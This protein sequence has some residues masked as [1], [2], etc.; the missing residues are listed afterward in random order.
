MTM[1][2]NI[3]PP[4]KPTPPIALKLKPPPSPVLLVEDYVR[5]N[6]FDKLKNLIGG[7]KT[8]NAQELVNLLQDIAKDQ[9]TTLDGL[10][11]RLYY[12]S[13]NYN[14]EGCDIEFYTNKKTPNPRYEKE[15]LKYE[16]YL[17]YRKFQEERLLKKEAEYKEKMGVY[18]KA[19]ADYSKFQKE[20]QKII[21]EANE[22][23]KKL[24]IK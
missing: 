9:E 13:D 4:K 6:N 16:K 17:I 3:I 2:N 23:I 12:Y 24:D 14:D 22:K 19:L 1:I 18:K 10:N 21:K 20:R 8:F 11:I 5:Q 7:A 15:K